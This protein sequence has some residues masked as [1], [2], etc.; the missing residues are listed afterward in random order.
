MFA[1]GGCGTGG[2]GFAGLV[3]VLFILLAIIF[4]FFGGR[5]IC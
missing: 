2:L 5:G 3:L 4:P 1:R